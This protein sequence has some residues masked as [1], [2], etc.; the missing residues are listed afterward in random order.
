MIQFV[1]LAATAISLLGLSQAVKLGE[2]VTSRVKQPGLP[3]KILVN[4]TVLPA[5]QHIQN[6]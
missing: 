5:R 2:Y 3:G 4:C 6:S 1:Y